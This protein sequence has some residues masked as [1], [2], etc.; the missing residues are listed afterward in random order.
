MP[1]NFYWRNKDDK[2]LLVLPLLY[3]NQ[4]KEGGSLYS[5][6]G[7]HT[8]EGDQSAGSLFWLYWFGGNAHDRQRLRHLLPAGLELPLAAVEH[9]RRRPGRP[10][11]A[12]IL[13]LHHGVPALV[14]RRRHRQGRG[15]RTLLPFFYWERSEHDQQ[16]MWVTPIGGYSRDDVDGSRTML[17][18]PLIFTRRDRT[19]ALHVITP[20]F[21][22]Y[23]EQRQPA[24][25]PA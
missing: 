23:R 3:W 2:N 11:A 13:A 6:I 4:H 8:R 10:S 24:R 14:E 1:L 18:L 5:L 12:A 25:P 19:S 20:A 7:Y 9:H 21:I 16:S 15:F 22:R 17:L